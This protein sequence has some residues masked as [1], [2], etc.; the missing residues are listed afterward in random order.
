MSIA[1]DLHYVEPRSINNDVLMGV[2]RY[3]LATVFDKNSEP[4]DHVNAELSSKGKIQS[5]G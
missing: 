1:S 3:A 5:V 2:C 4:L